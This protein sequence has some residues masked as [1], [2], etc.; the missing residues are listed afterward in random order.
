MA[1]PDRTSALAAIDMAPAS[2]AVTIT[3][4][5]VHHLVQINGAPSEPAFKSIIGTLG[6]S[7]NSGAGCTL[8]GSDLRLFWN[9]PRMWLAECDSQQALNRLCDAMAQTAATVTDISHGRTVLRIAGTSAQL[10]LGKGCPIDL[11]T[12]DPASVV[13]TH[14][15]HLNVMIHKLDH[16]TFD[17]YVFRSF[18]QALYEWLD[19]AAIQW[20]GDAESSAD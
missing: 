19:D 18:G 17:I 16:Q 20:R 12:L 7:G 3:E 4:R 9:G 14:L 2:A 1:N 11:E 10:L 13:S 15:G 6:L 8:T 5:R